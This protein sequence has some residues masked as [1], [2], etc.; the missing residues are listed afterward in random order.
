MGVRKGW[1][2]FV[3]MMKILVP[4]SLLTSMVTW[5]GWL[6]TIQFA[7]Q[8]FMNWLSLP[9]AAAL[10]LLIGIF[11]GLYGAIATMVVLPLSREH[12]TLIAIF[13]LIA[14]NLIQEGIIQG[15]SGLNVVT[16][17][18]YRL[19]AAIAAVLVSAL[20]LDVPGTIPVDA[21]SFDKEIQ[22]FAAMLQGWFLTT[23]VLSLKIFIIIMGVLML[24]EVT[25]ALGWI[26]R[27]VRICRPALRAL[28]LTEKSGIIWMTSAVFGLVYAA[29]VVVEEAKG[30]HFD[31]E[32]LEG[33]HLSVGINH[34]MIEDPAI[35]LA[36]GLPPFW[37]WV[38][39]LVAA[40][41]A[42]RVFSFWQQIINRRK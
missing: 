39:R 11:T 30:G 19:I 28:G 4:I 1:S 14:H 18:L 2:G 9:A 7:I 38:P 21:V 33:L 25:K 3:W 35:F 22:P 17:T 32:E 42:V 12:M 37:L 8:P 23:L 36:L 20:F 34:A 27:F 41:L 40:I 5:A 13:L 29:A 31:K 10:P 26:G 24:L 6:E 16:A 15:K